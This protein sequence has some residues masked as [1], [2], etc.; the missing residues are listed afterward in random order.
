MTRLVVATRNP[1]KAREFQAILAPW[2][3]RVVALG[4][5]LPHVAPPEETGGS[6]L[7]NARIK[8]E[9]ACAATGLPALADD[10]G[11]E[12][13]GL[14]WRPGPDSA[15]FAGTARDD[16][17]N[18]RLLLRLLAEQPGASRRARYVAWL[19]LRLPDGREVV[20]RGEC[21][22]EIAPAPRGRGGFGYDPLF[23][24]PAL[25]RTMAELDPRLKNRISHRAQAAKAL[26]PA[27]FEL[28]GPPLARA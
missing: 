4:E 20:A 11:V 26:Y 25:G 12:V 13:E 28:L 19:V 6:Y 21:R 22:G 5:L 14:G 9:A 18:N 7:A 27:L 2:A 8:A 23:L 10:S 15:V 3:D 1:G 24:L 17:A 16:E